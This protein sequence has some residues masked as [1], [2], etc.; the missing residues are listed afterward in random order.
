MF[1]KALIIAALLL[2]AAPA[3]Y[4]STWIG[5]GGL[6]YGNICRNGLYFTVYPFAM[7]QPVGSSCP[8]RNS[9]GTVVGYGIVSSE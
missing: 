9:F 1:S 4:A 8:I 5:Y 6:L 3:S 7:A 2:A